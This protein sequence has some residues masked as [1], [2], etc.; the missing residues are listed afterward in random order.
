MKD[1][2][3]EISGSHG[4]KYEDGCLLGCWAVMSGRGLPTFQKCLLPPSSGR[5]ALMMKA[6]S[7]PNTLV[8]R[9]QTTRR[10]KPEDSHLQSRGMLATV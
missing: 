9:Y 1:K 3:Y 2:E 10:N 4:D 7:T 5:F 6:A 8:N